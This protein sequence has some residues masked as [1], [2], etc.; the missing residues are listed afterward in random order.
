MSLR[1]RILLAFMLAGVLPFVV[2]GIAS[3]TVANQGLKSVQDGGIAAVVD[4]AKDQLIVTRDARRNQIKAYLQEVVKVLLL[5]DQNPQLLEYLLTLDFAFATAGGTE[6][7][8]E[9]LNHDDYKDAHEQFH[10]GFKGYIDIYGFYDL[11]LFNTKGDLVYTVAKEA[12][13]ATNLVNGPYASSGLGKVFQ[14]ALQT[15]KLSFSDFEPYAPSN[16]DPAAFF[17]YPIHD[18]SGE[19]HGVIALQLSIDEISRVMGDESGMGKTGETYLVGLDHRLR[20]NSRLDTNITVKNSFRDNILIQ[21]EA[22]KAALAGRSGAKEITDYRGQQVLSAYAPFEFAGVT[23]ALLAEIDVAEAYENAQELAKQQGNDIESAQNRLFLWVIGVGSVASAGGILIF[24]WIVSYLVA[25]NQRIEKVAGEV[26]LAS[27]QLAEGA[28]SQSQ[29]VNEI[30][31]SVEELIASIQDVAE[32]SSNVSNAAHNSAEEA[33]AGGESV[34]LAIDAM[35]LISDSS[36]QINE[37]IV[38]ISDIAEQTNLLALNAAI[39]A[40]RAG[41]QGKGFAVVA[42]EVRK[43]A[44]RSAT[45]AQEITQ[46]IKQSSGRV[47][48]GMSLSDKA[49]N[50]LESIVDHVDKTAEM[51]EQ[52]SAATEQQAATSNAIKDGMNH[53][54]ETIENNAS[55]SQNL[56]ASAQNMLDEIYKIITGKTRGKMATPPPQIIKE[57]TVSQPPQPPAS[58]TTMLAPTQQTAI[59]HTEKNADY[60]DW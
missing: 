34:K 45:A 57:E 43:L 50:M 47:E 21:T 10:P 41:E 23:W 28:Q 32:H 42:D 29:T 37:I 36:E 31:S 39:E 20:S 53:I 12:D 17:G 5:S 11:F 25:S 38:V 52:I 30:T 2:S 22:T 54:A 33:K 19:I 35:G 60:L 8:M 24:L 49:G 6:A 44:E 7:G 14:G 51:V 55:S 46:L 58:S 1:A 9:I 40:A 13:F 59:S 4:R 48:E 3:Y 15:G 18:E 27:G 56:S 16:N 26:A